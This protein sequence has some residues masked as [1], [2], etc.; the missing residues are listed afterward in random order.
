[1]RAPRFLDK[2][3]EFERSR[4]AR[5][6]ARGVLFVAGGGLGDAVLLSH[7][8]PRLLSMARAGE[9]V[10]LVLRR[11]A[12]KMAFLFPSEVEIHAV[13]FDR[14]RRQAGYRRATFA[15]LY[16]AHYRLAVSLDYL[17]HPDLDEAL[18]AAAAAD[19]AL[20]MAPRPWPKHDP[21]LSRNRRLY[22]RLF[23]SGPPAGDK[24]LRWARFADWLTGSTAPS[25]I[26]R[27]P[28]ERLAPPAALE[29]PTVVV[30]PFSAV[31]AKQI[32]PDL[33]RAI[34]AAIPPNHR[35]LLTGTPGDLE[36]NPSC[37]A[38]LD[39]PRVAFEPATFQALVPLLR[40]ARLAVSVD[41]A[42]MHLAI[43]VGTPTL[44]LAS[45]AYV[46]EIVP[47]APETTPPNA[48]FLYH[49]LPCRS[50]LGACIHPAEA[51]MFPCVA[52]LDTD[53]VVRNVKRL[54]GK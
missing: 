17:R 49:D 46:G 6:P 38:L 52:R 48:H 34:F 54:L 31:R 37:R 21:A 39:L 29:A 30:Q 44:G 19:T 35:I 22:T 7:V 9:V 50:C 51:G 2:L 5:A 40:A 23:E 1:M 53:L 20:A 15:T 27:L 24:L 11:D 14:L 36:G 33:W 41:T 13:D 45:A 47:Y 12:A 8:F 25:P 18:I 42:L 28:D 4:E 43:A 26:A 32:A 10:A 3:F 16:R